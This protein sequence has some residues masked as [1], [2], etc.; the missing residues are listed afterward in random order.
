[1]AAFHSD[2]HG[3]AALL[4]G[5]V[6]LLVLALDLGDLLLV[7]LEDLLLVRRRDDV[8]L[9]D[10]HP[11]LGREVEPEVLERVEH[12]RDRRGAVGLD[13][14]RDHLVDAALLQRPVDV[15]V[16]LGVVLVA[17]RVGERA[18]DAVVE[19]DPPDRGQEVLVPGA[20]VL[21]EVVQLHEPVLERQLGLLRG[22]EAG[23]AWD[24][25]FAASSSVTSSPQ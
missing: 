17:E 23:A 24:S 13:E 2:G 21:G 12:E 11:G 18:L 22:A 9:G 16:A 4:G 5:D 10:R 7:A 6:A 15:L 1:M 8:V 25:S 20:P 19:D 3:L 14:V